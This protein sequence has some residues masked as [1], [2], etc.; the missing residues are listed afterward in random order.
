MSAYWQ[1]VR[2]VPLTSEEVIGYNKTDSLAEIQRMEAEGDT[3]RNDKR[4]R[5]FQVYDLVIGDTYSLGNGNKISIDNLKGNFN[6]VDGFHLRTGIKFSHNFEGGNWLSFHPVIRY[7]FSRDVVNYLGEAQYG[8]GERTK[9]ND[10]IITGG[11]YI[12]QFNADEPIHPF[13]N[14]VFSL[15]GERN[16][17][18]IYEHDFV[19]IAYNKKFTG[20]KARLRTNLMWAD[21]KSLDNT[22]NY[23]FV[24]RSEGY[25]SNDP[26]NL[27]LD[28]TSFPNH[29]ALTFEAGLELRPGL[30]YRI[31]NG[32]KYTIEGSSPTINLLYRT[33]ISGIAGS[34]VDYHQFEASFRHHFKIGIQGFADLAVQAGTFLGE[35]PAYFMDY[36][37]FQG[38]QTPFITSDPVSSYRLLDYYLYSTNG[39][40]ISLFAQYQFRKFLLTRIPKLRLVGIREGFFANYLLNDVANHYVE[41]GYGINYIFRVI[42]L[43]AVTSFIDGNYLD[44]GVRIGIATNLEDIF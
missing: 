3:L 37:H 4:K 44:F 42:R 36:K 41:A 33:G 34:D 6:T 7:N 2:P 38:N 11:R 9:R 8:F 24:N 12:R 1:K 23:S 19:K 16:Y 21:R 10:L 39:S 17:M 13:I 15:L 22:T 20:S 35:E 43:E 27:V 32:N 29:Q 25:T 28:S 5:G 30:K 40:Y 31:Y 18:K 14:T 26:D